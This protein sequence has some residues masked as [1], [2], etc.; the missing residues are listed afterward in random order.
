MADLAKCAELVSIII[1]RF[2]PGAVPSGIAGKCAMFDLQFHLGRA[3]EKTV[4]MLPRGRVS[5]DKSE[6]VVK[7]QN[8]GAVTFT[9]LLFRVVEDR[10]PETL[11]VNQFAADRSAIHRYGLVPRP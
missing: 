4:A 10:N 11:T 1:I 7:A 9:A 3:K 2:V 8:S 6:G 5:L